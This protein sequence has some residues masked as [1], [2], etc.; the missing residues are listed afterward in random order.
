MRC[1]STPNSVRKNQPTVLAIFETLVAVVAYWGIAWWL[2]THIHLL[3]SICVAPLLLLRSKESTEKGV[4]WFLAYFGGKTKIDPKETPVRF[5]AIILLGG[6]IGG[7]CVYALAK[8]VLIEQT[9]WVLLIQIFGLGILGIVISFMVAVAGVG[10][11]AGAAA[12]A[13]VILT[14]KSGT[15]AIGRAVARAEPRGIAVAGAVMKTVVEVME[16]TIPVPTVITIAVVGNI[17]VLL[18]GIPFAAGIWLRSLAVRVLATLRHPLKGLKTLPDNWRRILW[19][20]DFH[21]IPE[22][23]PGL[24]VHNPSFMSLSGFLNENRNGSWEQRF[25]T[26]MVIPTLFLPSFLYRWSLKSTCWLYL[27]LIYLGGGLSGPFDAKEKGLLVAGLHKSRW[28]SSRRWLMILV[29][30]SAVVTTAINHPAFGTVMREFLASVPK[31]LGFLPPIFALLTEHAADLAYLWA[32]DFNGPNLAPWQWL[33]ILGAVITGLIFFYSDRVDR[34]WRLAKEQDSAAAPESA[35]VWVLL[36]M[37][38]VRNLCAV[39]YVLLAFGYVIL[40][41]G[42]VDAAGFAGWLAPVDA[43]YG[44]YL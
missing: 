23:V 32:F 18:F 14:L 43:L 10:A 12:I 13:R 3:M 44:P 40:A 4:L 29:V 34:V 16:R 25:I 20:L 28:E 30:G 8:S 41:L 35:Q 19:A 15:G 39:L 31:F 37:A 21:H 6:L 17:F 33:N 5:W 22:L 38:R 36:G 7:I 42:G 2:D 24:W 9:G 26:I 11:I 27:P 1:I